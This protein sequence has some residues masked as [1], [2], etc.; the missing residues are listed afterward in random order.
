M[1][2]LPWDARPRSSF[3]RRS[4]GLAPSRRGGGARRRSRDR[5]SRQSQ[6]HAA[7]RRTDRWTARARLRRAHR[8]SEPGVS[9][10]ARAAPAARSQVAAPQAGRR[11]RARIRH[12]QW[13]R[14]IFADAPPIRRRCRC[15]RSI[16]WRKREARK[17]S[18]CFPSWPPTEFRA[19]PTPT[20]PWRPIRMTGS[21]R[22]RS[23]RRRKS[24][25]AD[26][27]RARRAQDPPSPSGDAAAVR[28]GQTVGAE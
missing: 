27:A 9:L 12:R 14:S 7:Q 21:I 22:N 5:R 3:T 10:G 4:R 1:E 28:A 20:S 18:R 13:C 24:R 26:R 19:S 17:P 15:A 2:I 25:R 6:R 11:D 8:R 16:S 23:W